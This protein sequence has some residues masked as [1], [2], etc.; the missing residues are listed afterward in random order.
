MEGK[1][2]NGMEEGSGMN[3]RGGKGVELNGEEGRE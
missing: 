3:W 1:E 2:K